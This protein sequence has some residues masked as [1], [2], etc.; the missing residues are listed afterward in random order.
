MVNDKSLNKLKHKRPF[1]RAA[2]TFLGGFIFAILLFV[3]I[4]VAT[5]PASRSEF[6]S[7]TCHE[8]NTASKA[9]ELSVHGAN[10]LGIR[11]ECVDCHLPPKENFFTH[12]ATKAFVG[13]TDV[14]IHLFG[15]DYDLEKSRQKAIEHMSNE[16]CLHC[17]DDLLARP[18]NSAA[19]KP[20]M[21]VLNRPDAEENRCVNCHEDAGHQR[22]SKLFSQ[23]K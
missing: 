23:Q 2:L 13:T 14:L 4:N 10:R 12:V 5:E 8:M 17:H 22:Q 6:C 21:E 15:E 3:F 20:H 11:V 9:W 1:K 18:T 7:S 16:T 19:R